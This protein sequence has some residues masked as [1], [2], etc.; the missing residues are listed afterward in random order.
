[1]THFIV[2][3]AQHIFSTVINFLYFWLTMAGLCISPV[4]PVSNLNLLYNRENAVQKVP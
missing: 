2:C 3:C 4:P 1:M